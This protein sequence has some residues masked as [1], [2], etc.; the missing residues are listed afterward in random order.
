MLE[1]ALFFECDKYWWA[2]LLLISNFFPFYADAKG[3][4]MPWSWALAAD[5]QLYIFLPLLVI[6]YKRSRNIFIGLL[7]FIFLAGTGIIAYVVS[8]FSL[9][10][11]VYSI[12]NWFFYSSFLN[13]PYCKLQVYAI[14]LASVVL[15]LD[16]M[17]YRKLD[18]TFAKLKYKKLHFIMNSKIFG[19]GML[20]VGLV[21]VI[22]NLFISYNCTLNPYQ[23]NGF[24]NIVFFTTTRS[25]Y[26]LG[27]ML[28]AF[29]IILGHSTAGKAILGN[30][31]FNTL[32]KLVYI[33][34]L[35]TPII[36]MCIYAS[37]W[38]GVFMSIVFN[39]TL[40]FGHQITAFFSA[41]FIY[42]LI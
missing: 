10:S 4:C 14:G 17:N 27:W 25:S 23:W 11:G 30:P 2:N 18:P 19:Y 38:D 33:A 37:T 39:M 29:H 34:Y 16:L 3:G 32:G 21:F 13:K 8:D 41:F 31:I 35:I 6:V 42:V 15:Y 24:E 12:E 20:I 28:I 26:A 1:Q 5:F 36:M 7:W 9:T 22:T 40:G